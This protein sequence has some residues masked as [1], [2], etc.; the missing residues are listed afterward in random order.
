[1]SVLTGLVRKTCQARG[2]S[3]VELAI[4]LP[5]LLVVL[6][7]VVDF[8]NLFSQIAWF[9]T[10]NYEASL[11]GASANSDMGRDYVLDTF[12]RLYDIHQEN[13]NARIDSGDIIQS[14]GYPRF[15]PTP[16]TVTVESVASPRRFLGHYPLSFDV[17]YVAPQLLSNAETNSGDLSEFEN[18]T[19]CF[20]NCDGSTGAG[21]C[22]A[23][24]APTGGGACGSATALNPTPT[25]APVGT[26]PPAGP[27]PTPGYQGGSRG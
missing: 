6:A 9:S 15:E 12:N 5:L 13:G 2:A 10:V 17:R 4:V 20:F 24:R 18:D 8:G 25:A 26:V 23:G 21:N 19:D 11:A 7:G 27:T 14:D 16:R 22:G 3:N 1:M